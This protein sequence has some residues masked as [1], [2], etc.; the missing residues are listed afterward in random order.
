M[1]LYRLYRE[2]LS[3]LTDLYKLTMAYA[4][5]KN[6]SHLNEAVFHASFRKNPFGGGYAIACGLS[7][8]VDFISNFRFDESDINYLQTLK[9]HDD[10]PLFEPG[11]LDYLA[12]MRMSVDIDAVA[13]GTVVFAH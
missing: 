6:G 8:V 7:T 13:D 12:T 4:H 11:F 3:L 9:G 2:S 1:A 10:K 5:W